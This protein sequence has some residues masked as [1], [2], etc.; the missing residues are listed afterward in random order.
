MRLVSQTLTSELR[1]RMSK[2]KLKETVEWGQ[3]QL[4]QASNELS[5]SAL[6]PSAVCVSLVRPQPRA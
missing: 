6:H 4:L 1:L 5:P 3:A 2:Q